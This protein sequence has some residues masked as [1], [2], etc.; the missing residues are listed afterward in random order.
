MAAIGGSELE[1]RLRKANG[2][3]WEQEGN[4]GKE[5]GM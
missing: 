4:F 1:G 5:N 2:S 3:L